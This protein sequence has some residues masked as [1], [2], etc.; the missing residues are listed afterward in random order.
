[1]PYSNRAHPLASR[2]SSWPIIDQ[3]EDAVPRMKLRM[4]V[5]R[6]SGR[7]RFPL[8]TRLAEEGSMRGVMTV[9]TKLTSA[10]YSLQHSVS[11]PG[12]LFS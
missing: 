11:A 3:A 1:M 8:G 7:T 2:L 9:P 12:V 6:A 10:R 4:T 5:S